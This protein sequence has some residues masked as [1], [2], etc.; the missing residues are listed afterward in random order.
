MN[1]KPGT[2]IAA[3]LVAGAAV[4]LAG[5]TIGSSDAAGSREDRTLTVVEHAVTDT[6]LDFGAQGDSRGDLLAFQNPVF[7]ASDEQRVGH[8]LGYCVRTRPGAAF[9]CTWTLVLKR[10]SI[11]VQG[12]FRDA[13]DST[14]AI[15]GGTGAFNGAEGS[16]RLHALDA[17]GTK[18]RFVYHLTS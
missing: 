4:I 16:M 18:Y 3:A 5:T 15:T 13:G 9:E 8:D 1:T 6:P 10:G 12:P 11:V 17:A 14:L 2:I 7:N